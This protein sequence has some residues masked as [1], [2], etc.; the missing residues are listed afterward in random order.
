M[1]RP[2]AELV[3][4]AADA[5]VAPNV[6][7]ASRYDLRAILGVSTDDFASADCD[8]GSVD[9]ASFPAYDTSFD[10]DVEAEFSG[11]IAEHLFVD[12]DDFSVACAASN[13]DESSDSVPPWTC[14]FFRAQFSDGIPSRP[15]K[16]YAVATSGEPVI[17]GKW[18]IHQNT[19]NNQME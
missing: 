8:N 10:V 9:G 15:S 3:S 2:S 16:S 19:H 6:G 4:I 1:N 13:C 7:S 14:L 5:A 12:G 17:A 11:S 18:G